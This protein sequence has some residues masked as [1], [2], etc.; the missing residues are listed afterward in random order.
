MK[1]IIL[2]ILIM[3]IPLHYK[4]AG[5]GKLVKD[6]TPL[7]DSLSEIMTKRTTV[8]SKLRLKAVIT[9]EEA[10]DFYF[11]E[12]L[13]DLPWK[14]QDADFFRKELKA[15]FPEKYKNYKAGA[16]YSNNIP[17]EKLISPVLHNNGKSH[18]SKYRVTDPRKN[19]LVFVKN[20]EKPVFNKGL[21]G[22][23]I[24]LWQSHGW[25]YET[26]NKRWQWQRAKFFR[27]VED[28]YTQSYVLPF[29]IPMLENAGAYVM[30]PRE[31]DTQIYEVISDND[32]A[33]KEERTGLIRKAGA[34]HE[35]GKWEDAGQGFADSLISYKRSENPFTMG[36]ARKAECTDN[37]EKEVE[38]KWIPDIQERGKYAVYISY[39]SLPKSTE[40][41]HYKVKHLGGVSEFIV[42]QKLGGGT[43]IYLGAFEFDKGEEFYVSLNNLYPEG[44]K[45]HK[46]KVVT[47]DAVKF[48]GGIGKIAR[49]E[50]TEADSLWS[51]S[52]MP[53]YLEGALYWM[54]WAGADTSL[55]NKFENEY[56]KDFA[57][58]GAWTSMMSG[59]SH[60]NPKQDGK[61]IPFDLSLAFHS[62]AGISPNDSVIGTLA[63]YTSKCEG[64]KVFPN[65]EDRMASREYSDY[66]Q[67]QIVNDLRSTYSKDWSRRQLRDRSYSESRTTS[68]PAM[69]LEILSHQ[70]FAD[71][72][73]GLDP[74]FRFTVSRSVYKG[75]LKFLSNRYGC[76]YAV[77]PLPI[78]S[79]SAMLLN[80]SEVTL[81]WKETEDPLEKT[82]G[83][84]G[85]ILY[86]RRDEGG[87]D[88][89]KIIEVSKD[90]DSFYS[91]VLPIE[92][93]CVYSYRIEAFNEGGKS[94]PSET[95]CVGI[96]EEAKDGLKQV[97][98]VNNFDR[99]SAPA[100]FDTPEYAGFYSS[101]DGGVPFGN[102][103]SYAGEMYE[104]RRNPIWVSDDNPGFGASFGNEA[105][106][107]IAGNTFDYPFIHGKA[108]MKAGYPFSSSSSLYFQKDSSSFEN[109]WALDLI[110]G[111]QVTTISGADS[112]RF[113][114][115]V[116]PVAMQSAIS[117]FTEKG[118]HIL[119]SGANIGTDVWDQV[120]PIAVD[121]AYRADTKTFIQDKLGYRWLTNYACKN[122][123]VSVISNNN[124]GV[125][126]IDQDL[127]FH[128]EPNENFYCVE[129]PDAIA[130][131][132]ENSFTFLR[133]SD[134]KLSA[135]VCYD[136]D[137]HRV[138]SLG[139]P[140]ETIESKY[141]M[142]KLFKAIMDFFE[143][144]MPRLS[145]EGN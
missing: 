110:C 121:S 119:I 54:Q 127:S 116:F 44:N 112:E 21:S 14:K 143:T 64:K 70:N 48:G 43:W 131:S 114:Y 8:S 67:S 130:P 9:R 95:L 142:E 109:I 7:C 108:L 115:Q 128:N 28:M 81:S 129:T 39:K 98:I 126:S 92:K 100:W 23:H 61:G 26:K 36:T 132:S 60:V 58:R 22:R 45:T 101:L 59:G 80:E 75:M 11:T 133:Y 4:M 37:P 78:N 99:I 136:S 49:G 38:A 113:N 31:R 51:T 83:A 79:F 46:G 18:I 90:K 138:V 29:L 77:Q 134:T 140:I 89:G 144:F 120:Y 50:E 91:I 72:K 107:K 106:K 40:E 27:T 137:K 25:Y 117:K 32:P 135:G 125:S 24:A 118:G 12:S 33:F 2:L 84:T 104:F 47:A 17:F 69:I 145:E 42:N 105:G 86:S 13:G 141:A 15:R 73:Y 41:A 62:D 111:K 3:T 74:R 122:G 52:G 102:D 19:N 34:Y 85:F 10:L 96:P 63:I 139:F 94:L 103:I 53:S 30:T 124:I 65:G 123:E 71:M 97:L 55:T 88:N 82:A 57:G 93:G 35:Y 16:I 66:V 56:T 20:L 5:Q 68:V 1:K 76:Q 87:F 6:F